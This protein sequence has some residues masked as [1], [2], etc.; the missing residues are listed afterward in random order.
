V[1]LLALL[2]GGRM[3]GNSERDTG[4]ENENEKRTGSNRIVS[5][6]SIAREID[7]KMLGTWIIMEDHHRPR[8]Q[9]GGIILDL[10]R[11][12]ILITL[13]LIHLGTHNLN[14]MRIHMDTDLKC[15]PCLFPL[16]RRYILGILDLKE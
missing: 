1:G 7:A 8:L 10:L 6:N 5:V 4:R 14:I 2:V 12:I 3:K 13:I 15:Y 11:T 9:L 16:H